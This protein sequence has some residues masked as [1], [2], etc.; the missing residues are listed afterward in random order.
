MQT[1]GST[2]GGLKFT[3]SIK[4][5]ADDMWTLVPVMH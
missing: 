4:T 1:S 2:Y 5:N 3:I